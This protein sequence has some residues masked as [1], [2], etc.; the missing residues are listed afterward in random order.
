[1]SQPDASVTSAV[2]SQ[3][4][5][6]PP[7]GVASGP[8]GRARRGWTRRAALLAAALLGT[9]ALASVFT[10]SEN[11]IPAGI[12][13]TT[14]GLCTFPRGCYV[15]NVG[16][17]NDGQCDD[18]S[19]SSRCRLVFV[20]SNAGDYQS[21]SG[22]WMP[23][24]GRPMP[25]DWQGVC[26]LS[27]DMGS[28]AKTALCA[29]PEMV[30]VARGPACSGYCVHATAAAGGGD[31]GAAAACLSGVPVPPQRRPGA[32]DGGTQTYCPLTD[33]TCCPGAPPLVDGGSSDG[34]ALS[35]GGAMS[36][37]GAADLAGR[38]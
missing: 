23:A 6:E 25:T 29:A 5:G 22:T 30:C 13:G 24:A 8:T 33:D 16:G 10:C 15:V 19:S 31:M 27:F 21:L 26:G 17:P 9:S 20:P 34:G 1:M 12:N 4:P 11:P 28:T 2:T 32:V 18:C 7:G 36:D 38:D 14:N 35:D 3:T 37:G